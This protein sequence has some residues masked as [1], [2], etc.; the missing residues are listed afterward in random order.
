METIEQRLHEEYGLETERK[1]E[2]L[3]HSGVEENDL[4]KVS[5]LS[6]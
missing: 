2:M 5:D 4:S 3:S 1:R 6:A